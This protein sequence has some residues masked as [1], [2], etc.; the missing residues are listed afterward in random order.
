MSCFAKSSSVF[1]STTS[2][3]P[4]AMLPPAV[5]TTSPS[6]PTWKLFVRWTGRVEVNLVKEIA[7]DVASVLQ[8]AVGVVE[9][10]LLFIAQLPPAACEL[11]RNPALQLT[12]REESERADLDRAWQ[13]V[14]LDQPIHGRLAQAERFSRFCEP[15]QTIRFS[16]SV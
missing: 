6:L 15:D 8:V 7:P 11:L 14:P 2:A 10:R 3:C 1:T 9:R 5:L 13:G 4:A 12:L 16:G